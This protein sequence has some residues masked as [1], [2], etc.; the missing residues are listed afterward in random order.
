MWNIGANEL[1]CVVADD[2]IIHLVVSN[3]HIVGKNLMVPQGLSRIRCALIPMELKTPSVAGATVG[4]RG[5]G[6]ALGLSRGLKAEL[7]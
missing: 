6:T 7:A 4:A 5:N 3:L 1:M 2:S